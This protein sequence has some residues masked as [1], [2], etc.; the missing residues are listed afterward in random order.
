MKPFKVGDTVRCYGF[1]KN[2]A[3]V[4]LEAFRMDA[5]VPCDFRTVPAPAKVI[6]I[7]ESMG[8]TLLDLE[9]E[10]KD[11]HTGAFIANPKQCRHLKKKARRSVWI[12]SATM[13]MSNSFIVKYNGKPETTASLIPKEGWVEFREVGK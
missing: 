6:R 4:D 2:V 12:N 3:S 1:V 10:N 11:G 9:I 7:F 13:F 8:E 5:G